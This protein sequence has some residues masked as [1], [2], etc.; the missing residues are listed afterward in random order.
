MYTYRP[1]TFIA[2]RTQSEGQQFSSLGSSGKGHFRVCHVPRRLY[3]HFFGG[4][5][6]VGVEVGVRVGVGEPG[7]GMHDR[8]A[9]RTSRFYRVWTVGQRGTTSNT[10]DTILVLLATKRGRPNDLISA[11]EDRSGLPGDTLITLRVDHQIPW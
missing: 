9:N 10:D 4:W 1:S 5:V 6:G 8:L 11:V 3:K 7:W 2:D